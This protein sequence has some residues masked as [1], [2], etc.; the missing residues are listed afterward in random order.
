[1]SNTFGEL[2]ED[3][4]KRDNSDFNLASRTSRWYFGEKKHL[5]LKIIITEYV[6]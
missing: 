5:N 6:I 3:V 2:L 4:M 1:M